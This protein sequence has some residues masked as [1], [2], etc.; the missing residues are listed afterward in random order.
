MF[1]VL[2]ACDERY[3]TTFGTTTVPMCYKFS[4]NFREEVRRLMM[5]ELFYSITPH[6]TT[7]EAGTLQNFP[8]ELKTWKFIG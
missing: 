8:M 5:Q 4:Y 7:S 1:W 6:L 2:E 3:P